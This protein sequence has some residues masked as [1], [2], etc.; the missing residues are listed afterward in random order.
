MESEG[1][2]P[3]GR[4][5]TVILRHKDDPDTELV[6]AHLRPGSNPV[7]RAVA[8]A[9]QHGSNLSGIDLSDRR[10]D[11]FKNVEWDQSFRWP[12]PNRAGSQTV[13]SRSAA[14]PEA[15]FEGA[16]IVGARWWD[17]DPGREPGLR[18]S[19]PRANFRNSVLQ[20]V[21]LRDGD[22]SDADFRG[23]QIGSRWFG[24]DSFFCNCKMQ[25]VDLR[26]ITGN[27]TLVLHACDLAGAKLSLA[28]DMTR[29][30][31]DG[32]TN[33]DK[34][35]IYDAQ[36]IHRPHLRMNA[37]ASD[38]VVQI[39][40]RAD[41]VP[42]AEAAADTAPADSGAPDT[43][44]PRQSRPAME[45]PENSIA[46]AV[47]RGET[48]ILR[49]K[50]DP[51]TQLV[52]AQVRSG[53]NATMRA[54]ALAAH[55]GTDMTGIDLSHR[56]LDLFEGITWTPYAG[57][58]RFSHD[59]RNGVPLAGASFEGA[60]LQ[61]FAQDPDGRGLL[62]YRFLRLHASG[63]N[64]RDSRLQAVGFADS[65]F[66]GADFRGMKVGARWFPK[67]SRMRACDLT[68]AD[69]RGVTGRKPLLLEA[70]DVAG[71]KVSTDQTLETLHFKDCQNLDRVE[72]YDP[73]GNKQ[74]HLRLNEQ[75]NILRVAAGETPR[76]DSAQENSV[77]E[78]GAQEN[79]A[80][81]R[82]KPA[83]PKL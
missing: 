63:A 57:R 10:I 2:K 5:E 32:C 80:P 60:R 77:Q 39:R 35:E 52:W 25:G 17:A 20:G 79:G 47:G 26:G 23:A 12:G 28:G 14:L 30:R 83:A 46:N 9:A 45:S 49:H 43:P 40:K 19:A 69:M 75:G 68:G 54:I 62:K 33:L 76:A 53:K 65:D 22:L 34:V 55:W 11:L 74:P 21:H 64:F 67:A 66:S 56:K 31:F 29:I 61:G 13:D 27:S 50:D 71:L 72:I 24:R 1:E 81:Y 3:I 44:R 82:E 8:L 38:E 37:N 70:C 59:G 15:S 48:V 51:D 6:F 16:Q 36:G 18:L 58:D 4:G 41:S 73:Q 78:N 7:M 42:E